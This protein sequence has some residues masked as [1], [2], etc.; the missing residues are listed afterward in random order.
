MA[1]CKAT[2]VTTGE[3]DFFKLFKIK[4]NSLDNRIVKVEFRSNKNIRYQY[5]D[6]KPFGEISDGDIVYGFDVRI[7]EYPVCMFISYVYSKGI[8]FMEGLGM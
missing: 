7:H 4:Y 2:K 8:Y 3:D 6:K 1:K 5:G